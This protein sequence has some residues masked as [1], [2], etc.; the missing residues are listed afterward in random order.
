MS[1]RPRNLDAA[2]GLIDWQ[3]LLEFIE[4]ERE[5]HLDESEPEKDRLMPQATMEPATTPCAVPIQE[6]TVVLSPSPAPPHPSSSAP[7]GQRLLSL[8]VLRGFTMFWI[9]GGSDLLLAIVT[10]LSSSSAVVKAVGAQLDHPKWEG[11]V[12]WD[13]IMP[14]FLFVVGAAMP[15]AFAGQAQKSRP[16]WATYVRIARRVAVLWFL[17]VLVQQVRYH[18]DEW[19][20]FFTQP[21]LFNNTLQAIAV[22]Y[23]V[24]SLALL[25]LSIRGQ[26]A[27]FFALL[28][29]YWA[30]IAFVPFEGYPAGTL[31]MTANFPLFVDMKFFADH[32]RDHY[33]TWTLTSLGFAA[34]VLMGA[35][36]GHILRS[37][38]SNGRRLLT[39]SALGLACAAS[40][41]VW[42]YW[43]PLNRHLWTSSM[44][45][46]AGGWSF[47]L[48]ALFYGVIDVAKL[49]KWWTFPFVVIGVNALLAYVLDPFIDK[50]SP[51]AAKWLLGVPSSVSSNPLVNILDP[52]IEI[53]VIWLVLWWLYRRRIFLRA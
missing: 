3:R 7:A 49:G 24:T 36:G 31:E 17:G 23:L 41:W 15:F 16:L 6:V 27:L 20:Q 1:H 29:G 50:L 26:V 37:R 19:P 28:L 35:M 13:A 32:R 11:F 4:R 38:L 14:I 42:S 46:W 22:G 47:L 5:L 43:L 9:I 10:I 25:H 52:A 44:I 30:C 8:D 34:S 45:L 39:L 18:Y 51:L 53:G 40:G 21:E 48:V 2:E 12:A 33:F